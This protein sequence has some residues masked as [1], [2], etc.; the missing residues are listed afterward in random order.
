RDT[1]GLGLTEIRLE[2]GFI[3]AAIQFLYA[4]S[5]PD[6][7]AISNSLEMRPWRTFNDYD[8]PIVRRI[9]ESEG[10]PRHLFGQRKKAVVQKYDDPKNLVLRAAFFDH[11]WKKR[12]WSRLRIHGVRLCNRIAFLGSRSWEQVR[13]LAG[14][15]AREVP[16]VFFA[17]DMDLPYEQHLWTLESLAR[18]L[19]SR[20][21]DGLDAFRHRLSRQSR[22]SPLSV[23]EH[24]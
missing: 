20:S 18:R 6:L 12:G 23:S 24:K 15:P 13:R 4:R 17:K 7:V 3:H 21:A 11:I 9:V 1:S 14:K 5:L 8:K 19:A 16:T 10:V 22:D 2:A